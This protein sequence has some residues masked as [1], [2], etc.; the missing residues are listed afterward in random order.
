MCEF[1]VNIEKTGTN[2]KLYTIFFFLYMFDYKIGLLAI[3]NKFRVS[4][5]NKFRV[6]KC[7]NYTVHVNVRLYTN[8]D[9]YVFILCPI[10]ICSFYSMNTEQ[11]LDKNCDNVLI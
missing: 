8:S 9:Y 7:N 6:S 2:F 10:Y 11:Y 5:C 4:K 1:H 3:A